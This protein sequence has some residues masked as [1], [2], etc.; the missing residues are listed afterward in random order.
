MKDK[1]K[2]FQNF[3]I[4]MIVAILGLMLLIIVGSGVGRYHIPTL[5][6]VK[7]V[8]SNVFDFSQTW[9]PQAYSVVMSLRLPRIITAV[10]VGGA[11]A[12]SGAVYQGVFKNPLVAPDMLGVSTG[13]CVG[14]S[15]GILCNAGGVTVQIVAFAG[16]MIAVVLATSIPKIMKNHSMMMLVLSGI[17]VTGLLDSIMGLLKYVAD[18]DTELAEITHWQLGSLTKATWNDVAYIGPPILLAGIILITIRWRINI[19]SLGE[20]EARTLGMDIRRIRGIVVVCATILTASAV[21]ISGTIGWIGLV[22]PHLCRMM[23]GPDN[24]KVIP[25]SIVMGAIFLL[26]IDTMARVITNAE[27]P[28]SILTGFVGAPFYFYLLLKQRMKLS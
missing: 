23:I 1:R 26:L 12:L 4:V 21:C 11:L 25:F 14:A 9:E 13:A 2:I 17:I 18:P 8:L 16:G 6:V 28:L 5:D 27:L 19:L 7:V 20:G 24:R 3:T 10:L 22:I 15:V